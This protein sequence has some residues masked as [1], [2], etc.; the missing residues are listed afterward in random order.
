MI[1][2]YWVAT[3]YLSFLLLICKCLVDFVFK[4]NDIKN[5]KINTIALNI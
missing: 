3:S 2:P 1:A 4:Q 5:N